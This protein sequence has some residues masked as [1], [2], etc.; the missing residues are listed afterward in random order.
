MNIEGRIGAGVASGLTACCRPMSTR[1]GAAI[2]GGGRPSKAD[3][4][5]HRKGRVLPLLGNG[6][7][8]MLTGTALFAFNDALGKWLVAQYPIGVVLLLRSVTG[9]VLLAPLIRRQGLRAL[10]AV[11]RPGLH[12]LRL[13]FIIIE[14]I[15]FYTAVREMPLADVMT[16]YLAAP[17]F[18][19]ALSVPILGETVGIRRWSAVIVGFIGVLIVMQPSGAAFSLPAIAAF[20]GSL[21]FAITMIQTRQ[22]RGAGGPTLITLQCVATGLAGAVSACFAFRMPDGVD[23]LLI[24]MLGIASTVAHIMINH[25]LRLS[26][27]AVVVPFQYTSIIWAVLLGYLI[28]GDMPTYAMGLGTAIIIASGLYVF[29]REQTVLQRRAAARRDPPVLDRS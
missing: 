15:L 22:L 12:L 1:S 3:Q 5:H 14:I 25:A 16:I 9:L 28:W 19:T 11:E 2:I 8:W 27:A 18:V 13:A 7:F 29:R 6:I 23:L 10:I 21:A 26:P 20:G 24:A 4:R 17:L